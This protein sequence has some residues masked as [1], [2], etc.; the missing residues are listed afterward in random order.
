M[1][2][3]AIRWKKIGGGSFYFKDQVIKS[4]QIFTATED[5]IP[6]GFRDVIIPLDKIPPVEVKHAVPSFKLQEATPPENGEVTIQSSTVSQTDSAGSQD[7]IVTSTSQEVP[8]EHTTSSTVTIIDK[9]VQHTNTPANIQEYVVSES[10][11]GWFNVVQI[12]SGKPIN[13][14]ALRK[15]DAEKLLEDLSR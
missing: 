13:N 2:N 15:A 4:G 9:D 11:R 3:Q 8:V 10:G 14:K 5:E 12:S 6:K 7:V 1:A